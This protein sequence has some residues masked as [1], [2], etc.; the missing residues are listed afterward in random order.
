MAGLLLPRPS[1]NQPVL[2]G[3]T[4]NA[5]TLNFVPPARAGFWL[6][7]RT[8]HSGLLVTLKCH[9]SCTTPA[10]RQWAPRTHISFID[11]LLA[12]DTR[13]NPRGFTALLSSSAHRN[14]AAWVY[15]PVPCMPLMV[16]LLPKHER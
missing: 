9:H 12:A 13:V 2:F 4:V 11:V 16:T 5:S 3:R 6:V 15:L 1:S 14:K 8:I 7:S 10:R